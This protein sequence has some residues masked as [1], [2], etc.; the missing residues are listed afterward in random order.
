M[1]CHRYCQLERC[2]YPVFSY[3]MYEYNTATWVFEWL[4]QYFR[5]SGILQWFGSL[6]WA[7]F[8]C[9]FYWF[10]IS[11]ILKV[12][13]RCGSYVVV[14]QKRYRSSWLKESV[15][16]VFMILRFSASFERVF[17]IFS[18]GGDIRRFS[19]SGRVSFFFRR[20]FQFICIIF[21]N[22]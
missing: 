4:F 21:T 3:N 2:Y 18:R 6:D 10:V 1:P 22:G 11:T 8:F 17:R 20:F 9:G 15:R 14:W 7:G 19:E 16:V 13:G 12:L 5:H